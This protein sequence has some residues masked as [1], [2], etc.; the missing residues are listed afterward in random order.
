MKKT[1]FIILIYILA[2]GFLLSACSTQPVIATQARA[3]AEL[4][5]YKT[6]AFKPEAG[7]DENGNASIASTYM[8]SAIGKEMSAQGYQF[9]EINPD[10]WVD[11]SSRVVN[12]PKKSAGPIINLGMFGSH[13]GVSLGVPLAGNVSKGNK[14]T[15]VSLELLDLKRKEVVWEGAY[16]AGLAES[17][18]ADPS[19]E[20]N[21][22]VNIL[23]SKFPVK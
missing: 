4:G 16:E 9:S 23:F 2:A 8:K 14:V 15:R 21:T 12:K 19:A 11:F 17:G 10:L 6:F 1:S 18:M 20:I 5:A 13:G 22:A 3:G 7:K